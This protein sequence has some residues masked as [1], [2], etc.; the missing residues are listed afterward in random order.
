MPVR[1]RAA[2]RRLIDFVLY[3][4]I[5]LALVAFAAI[6]AIHAVRTGG[7]GELPL[8]WIGLVGET[9]VLFGYVGRAM[10]PYWRNGR[11]WAGFLGFFAAHSVVYII[12]LL[13]TEQFPLLWFVFI[14]YLEWAALA[15]L[16]HLLLREHVE[17]DPGR[18]HKAS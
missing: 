8:K 7:K 1:K 5:G 15:Y 12:V 16:L 4:T 2:N 13:R 10:R 9:A 14:G 11:F 6:Y 17:T 18:C 3:I